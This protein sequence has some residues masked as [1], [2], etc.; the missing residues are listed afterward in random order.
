MTEPDDSGRKETAKER[1]VRPRMT[2]NAIGSDHTWRFQNEPWP[3]TSLG[4]SL[5][6]Y[7]LV[8]ASTYFSSSTLVAETRA[9]AGR[10]CASSRPVS[11]DCCGAVPCRLLLRRNDNI[12]RLHPSP[13]VSS[14]TSHARLQSSSY[15]GRDG[16]CG[17]HRQPL[18][19]TV[20]RITQQQ[21]SSSMAER[22]ECYAI[23]Y[24]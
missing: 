9:P 11:G 14:Q 22:P 2:S 5:P 18:S 10:G 20:C 24:S 3:G 6:K 1:L 17:T 7:S 19:C 12:S 4:P 21:T 15:N 13:L 23:R 16:R 8:R